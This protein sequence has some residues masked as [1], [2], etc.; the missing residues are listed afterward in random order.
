[1]QRSGSPIEW[2]CEVQDGVRY[3]M[4]WGTGWC[5]VQDVVDVDVSNWKVD[6][7]TG[8][9]AYGC[10][11]FMACA[12]LGPGCCIYICCLNQDSV[13]S[14]HHL[15]SKGVICLLHF[16][17]TAS[18][19]VVDRF[20]VLLFCTLEQTH[21]TH[22][23]HGQQMMYN[24]ECEPC[25]AVL[26]SLLASALEKQPSWAWLTSILGQPNGTWPASIL[27]QPNWAW[28]ASIL[29]QPI[30]AWLA[31]IFGQPSWAWLT[32]ILGQPNGA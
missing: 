12:W 31:S 11:L 5:E 28:P 21:C 16:Q 4:V 17:T 20:Y 2:W 27:G 14:W 18:V 30:W 15:F 10:D 32:S 24:I 26:Q 23:C 9:T 6:W 19:V 25:L 13:R 1:M 29:G 3:R 7:K 8:A 22:L